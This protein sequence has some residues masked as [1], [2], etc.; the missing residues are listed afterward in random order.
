MNLIYQ[1]DRTVLE[2]FQTYLNASIVWYRYFYN[3][4]IRVR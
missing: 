3:V 4:H 1:N 2:H